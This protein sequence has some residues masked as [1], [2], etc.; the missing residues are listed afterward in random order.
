MAENTRVVR[1]QRMLD[2]QMNVPLVMNV[3]MY[4]HVEVEACLMT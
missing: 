2:T 3:Y 1:E 4:A